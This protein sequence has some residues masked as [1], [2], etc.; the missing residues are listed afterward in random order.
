MHRAA[1]R[2]VRS[3]FQK[4]T[5]VTT[6]A[7]ISALSACQ[8]LRERTADAE[9]ESLSTYSPT[10]VQLFSAASFRVKSMR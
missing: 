7:S 3:S 1:T 6:P 9:A 5:A 10:M 8:P 2:L 4:A